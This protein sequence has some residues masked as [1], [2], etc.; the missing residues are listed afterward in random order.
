MFLHNNLVF[1]LILLNV[2]PTYLTAQDT[3]MH[4]LCCH[5]L[6]HKKASEDIQKHF[7]EAREAFN[8]S[9]PTPAIKEINNCPFLKQFASFTWFGSWIHANEWQKMDPDNK[10][11]LSFHEAAHTHLNH[12]IKQLDA[13]ALLTVGAVLTKIWPVRL[14]LIAG[15]L[16][17]PLYIR[18]CEKEADIAAAKKLISCGKTHIV[19]KQIDELKN[20]NPTSFSLWFNSSAETINY[21]QNAIGSVPKN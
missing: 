18:H 1:L 10:T 19:Q 11:W 12:P 8:I 4:R 5:L 20:E 3:L 9:Q 14:V 21:L 6:G 13:C 17:M 2:I 7:H 15:L 16:A